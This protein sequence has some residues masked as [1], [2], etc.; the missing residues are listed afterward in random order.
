[1]LKSTKARA[2]TPKG[3][4]TRRELIIN[5]EKQ[6]VP[7]ANKPIINTNTQS[8]PQPTNT[9]SHTISVEEPAQDTSSWDK[10]KWE[11]Y[12]SQ[13]SPVDG[14]N[15]LK[16]FVSF[17]HANPESASELLENV[18]NSRKL[19]LAQAAVMRTLCERFLKSS[20]SSEKLTGA[21]VRAQNSQ[22]KPNQTPLYASVVVSTAQVPQTEEAWRAY[23]IKLD[24]TYSDEQLKVDMEAF[25]IFA[26]EHPAAAAR[27]AVVI[28]EQGRRDDKDRQFIEI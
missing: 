25:R 21:Q 26:S 17:A 1:M 15:T 6:V 8:R 9:D 5:P 24:K 23:F 18:E 13:L 12:L 4:E 11:D 2:F 16:T 14:T 19:S 27:A 22:I 7:L 28:H 10:S 3:Q 20:I